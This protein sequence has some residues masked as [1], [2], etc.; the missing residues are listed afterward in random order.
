MFLT[1]RISF[2]IY[3]R[4]DRDRSGQLDKK[5]FK[6]ALKSLGHNK[7]SK[8]VCQLSPSL[9]SPPFSF[10]F[11]FIFIFLS[12]VIFCYILF[13]LMMFQ[14]GGKY[15]FMTID[16]DRSGHVSSPFPFPS[17]LLFVYFAHSLSPLLLSF[18]FFCYFISLIMKRY[19]NESSVN[20]GRTVECIA[21]EVGNN[22]LSLLSCLIFI[23]FPH[24]YLFILLFL[25]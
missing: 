2:D 1:I 5:E 10:H 22:F 8:Q 13:L 18:V 11:Y 12:S 20:G 9:F 4:Y 15:I 17:S 25:F 16:K 21:Q 23:S 14:D 6:K 3:K 24:F 7:H 19:Q